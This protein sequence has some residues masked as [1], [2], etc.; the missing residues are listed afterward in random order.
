[1]RTVNAASR[2][3]R[4]GA[5]TVVGGRVGL[6]LSPKLLEHLAQGREVVLV[7]GTNG[8]TTT[9]ALLAAAM[10]T[11]SQVATNATGSNMPEG[12]VAALGAAPDAPVA[13]LEC[14]EVWLGKVIVREHPAAVVLLNLSR[15]Q[16]DR[17]SEVRNVAAAWR[18]ALRGFEGV[19]VANADDPLVVY[20]ATAASTTSWYAGGFDFRA[21]ATSCPACGRHLDFASDTWSCE[22]GLVRPTPSAR[23]SAIGAELDGEEVEVAL[24][25]PGAFNR[26]NATAALLAAVRLGVDPSVA[27]TAIAGVDEVAGR[28]SVRTLRG[29]RVRLLLAKNPAGWQALLD[30]VAE[31]TAPLVLAVNA[32]VADGRDPSWLYDVEFERLAG[33]AVVASGERWRDLSTRLY[34]ADVAHET[35]QDL[36]DA[37]ALAAQGS[38]TVDVI[39]NYTAFAALWTTLEDGA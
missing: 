10:S 29:I 5:G 24:Q 1:M 20:A 8:K 39:A 6:A 7:S 37:V 23:P 38:P 18:D 26:A 19:C 14:D 3:S 17:T 4:R 13:V 15:D 25:L 36:G 28:F 16:L 34:Y 2:R 22:C 33:R 9:T 12:H 32:R 31:D 35:R 11:R 21:D 27:A 30:L